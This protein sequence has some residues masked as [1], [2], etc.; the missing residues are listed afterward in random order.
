MATHGLFSSCGEQGLPSGCGAQAPSRDA[1][2]VAGH[3][4]PVAMS[5]LSQSTGSGAQGLLQSWPVGPEVWLLV[6]RAQAQQLWPPGLA[7]PWCVGSSGSGIE[8]VFPASADGLFA[9]EPPGKPGHCLLIC[10]MGMLMI[11]AVSQYCR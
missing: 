1:L 4:L 8:P 2:S 7:A 9:T 11:V 10:I 3:R 6:S 5:S